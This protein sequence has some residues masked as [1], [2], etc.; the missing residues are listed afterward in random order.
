MFKDFLAV[1]HY[2]AKLYVPLVPGK[3]SEPHLKFVSKAKANPRGAVL[4][5]QV[6]SWDRIHDT[7]LSL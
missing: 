1:T 2:E 6:G 5:S 4:P 3:H 7:S